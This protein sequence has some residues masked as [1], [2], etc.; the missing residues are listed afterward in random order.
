MF[1]G[2]FKYAE[3]CLL[4]AERFIRLKGL[5]KTRKS[6]KVRLLHHFYSYLRILHET[7]RG[8]FEV[9]GRVP[10]QLLHDSS[11]DAFFIESRFRFDPT[12]MR[13][14]ESF[15]T[16]IKDTELAEGDL[17]L[18]APGQWER[19]L[20][21]ECVG[22][23]ESFMQLLSQVIRLG[24]EVDIAKYCPEKGT[25]SLSDF[26]IRAKDLEKCCIDWNPKSGL[27]WEAE[28][29]SQANDRYSNEDMLLGELKVALHYALLIYFHRRVYDVN[30]VVL[31]DK[32]NQTL[33]ILKRA[34]NTQVDGIQY[35]LSHFVW[36]GFI[37][38][39]ES[40][41]P[42]AQL[43]FSSWFDDCADQT[44][45]ETF[46]EARKVAQKVWEGR[47]KSKTR[48]FSWREILTAQD[49]IRLFYS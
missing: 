21:P 14:T 6:R 11:S 2:Q 12:C 28:D 46:T 15:T 9:T 27:D 20:Y 36:P 17:H 41:D 31:Q 32:V 45:L 43:S 4:D 47:R 8:A 26:V 13:L 40:L 1:G 23:P 38:A 39:C 7:T 5:T 49:G 19:T 33:D 29:D 22:I 35:T 25:L 34:G 3:A 42:E 48:D 18:V 44:G 24:N 37:A 16:S 10:G 30:A